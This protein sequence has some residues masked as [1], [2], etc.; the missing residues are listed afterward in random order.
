MY[1]YGE[2]DRPDRAA[3]RLPGDDV[4]MS[5][6]VSVGAHGQT[7][8]EPGRIERPDIV[9]NKL[10]GDAGGCRST[11]RVLHPGHA[12]TVAICIGDTSETRPADLWPQC[13][14]T[15]TTSSLRIHT[16]RR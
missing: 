16:C 15:Q 9:N 4:I 13:N 11:D 3:R 10:T 14:L 2:P 8:V 12:F 1:V 7:T 6:C 5:V